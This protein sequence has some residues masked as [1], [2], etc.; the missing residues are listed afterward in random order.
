MSI[1]QSRI[2]RATLLEAVSPPCPGKIALLPGEI[3]AR[4]PIIWPACGGMREI[5]VGVTS[6]DLGVCA[7]LGHRFKGSGGELW[8]YGDSR[9]LA[10][11]LAATEG[12]EDGF[13]IDRHARSI[14]RPRGNRNFCLMPR[15]SVPA[16]ALCS[17]C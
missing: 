2:K 5:L 1:L 16:L 15:T 11:E 6:D 10:V 4:Y 13:A 3:G 9:G 8:L 12:N 17:E 14:S 7:P